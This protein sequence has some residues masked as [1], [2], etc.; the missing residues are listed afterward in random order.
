MESGSS[1]EHHQL[2][3][4][5]YRYCSSTNRTAFAKPSDEVPA[6]VCCDAHE[7]DY[8]STHAASKSFSEQHAYTNY[9]EAESG[10]PH[11][12][13]ATNLNRIP[14]NRRCD[15]AEPYSNATAR[16]QTEASSGAPNERSSSSGTEAADM[17][18]RNAYL[19]CGDS[20]VTC[21]SSDPLP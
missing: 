20:P 5:M 2:R 4:T 14:D 18:M 1:T 17:H 6:N 7:A 12:A 11:A 9:S 15:P 8:G 21:Q 10:S 16:V 13:L 19:A 3:C